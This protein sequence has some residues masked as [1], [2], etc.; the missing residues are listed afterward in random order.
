G[1]MIDK[2]LSSGCKVLFDKWDGHNKHNPEISKELLT[3]ADIVFCEWG[4]GNAVW[5]SENLQPHQSMAVRVHS[6]ELFLPFLDRIDHSKV[7]KYIFVGEL[8]RQAAIT[9]HGVPADKT[10][11]LPNLVDINSLDKPKADDAS[12]TLGM[13]GIVPM[14][15][16]IDRALDLLESL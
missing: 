1:A 6:Q 15:K 11:V 7:G 13:V 5:Y 2:L 3:K 10:I 9:S 14:S 16:R 4:L 12:K 8:I